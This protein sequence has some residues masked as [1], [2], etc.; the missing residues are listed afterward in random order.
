MSAVFPHVDGNSP[1]TLDG[2]PPISND[3]MIGALQTSM[4][5]KAEHSDKKKTEPEELQ[6]LP[7]LMLGI[8]H[9]GVSLRWLNPASYPCSSQGDKTDAGRQAAQV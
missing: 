6:P 2:L 3:G 8:Y 5:G 4:L 9:S 1:P 7:G